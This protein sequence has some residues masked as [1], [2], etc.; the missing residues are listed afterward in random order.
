MKWWRFL[1]VALLLVLYFGCSDSGIGDSGV[2]DGLEAS[3]NV[4]GGVDLVDE[5]VVDVVDE[6]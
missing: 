6:G 2:V 4:G 3:L 1:L 5:V